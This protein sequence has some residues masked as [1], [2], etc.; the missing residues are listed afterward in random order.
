MTCREIMHCGLFG[1]CTTINSSVLF[2]VRE[3]SHMYVPKSLESRLDSLIIV[4]ERTHA[5][6]DFILLLVFLYN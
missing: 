3:S 5:F 2:I 4:V 6:T 1:C